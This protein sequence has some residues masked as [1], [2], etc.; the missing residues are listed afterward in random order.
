[1]KLRITFLLPV[2]GWS[3]GNRVVAIYA[4]WLAEQGHTVV[5]VS[6]SATA[7]T[8]FR[9][10]K[11]LMRG[12]GWPRHHPVPAS[13]MDDL[14]VEHR[15]VPMGRR[16]TPDDVPSADVL[17]CT[18]WETVEWANGLPPDRGVPVHFVQHHEVFD[19]LPRE[20]CEAV[21]RLPWRKIVIA[22]WLAE[23]MTRTY[24]AK[25]V[26]LVPNAVDH[27]IFHAP[28]RV[29][30]SPVTIGTLYHEA[31]FKGL[32]VALAALAK[33]K[34]RHPEVVILAFGS[35][36]PTGA[37]ALPDW[38]E[39]CVAP[40]Q[41]TLRALYARCDAW[42]TTSRTEGFNLMAMEAM[43]CRTP[44]ISTRTGW[45]AEAVVDGMNGFLCEVDD[46]GA[47]V[48]AVCRIVEMDAAQ[49][50]QMSS[51]AFATVEHATWDASSRL[52]EAALSR[53]VSDAGLGST[54]T[55]DLAGV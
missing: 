44:V 40:P 17:V 14:N 49:W 26:E 37:N 47:V 12:R 9:R 27:E 54:N 20:R 53:A 32:D 10:M 55:D 52:F 24:D 7:P 29:K 21:Y 23:V 34:Q 3:G 15:V 18:W 11:S 13:Y 28:V 42:L 5:L 2:L 38:V 50:A 8:L 41:D 36:P 4:Q 1:M 31:S 6:R 48:Q 43:A 22:R 51:N 46:V 33:V 35:S 16:L 39:L 30:N 19:Y 45:P 25:K